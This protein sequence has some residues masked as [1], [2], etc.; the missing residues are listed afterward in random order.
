MSVFTFNTV[1]E[2]FDT[3]GD[4]LAVEKRVAIDGRPV[5]VGEV[6]G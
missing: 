6:T 5:D 4:S 2:A 3:D 1:R